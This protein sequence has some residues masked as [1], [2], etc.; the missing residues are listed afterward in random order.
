[1]AREATVR[2]GS[3]ATAADA[4]VLRALGGGRTADFAWVHPGVVLCRAE[5]PANAATHFWACW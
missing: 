2:N 4:L 3:L 1:M 5:S